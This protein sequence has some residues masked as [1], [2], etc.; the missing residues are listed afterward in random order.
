LVHGD[1]MPENIISTARHSWLL[2]PTGFVGDQSFDWAT[3]GLY[4]RQPL[5][6]LE[7][8]TSKVE[9]RRLFSWAWI[10]GQLSAQQALAAGDVDEAQTLLVLLPKLAAA[11]PELADS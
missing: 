9:R 11:V 10:R 1:V 8:L 2:D 7:E 4:S 3:L 6:A 5:R